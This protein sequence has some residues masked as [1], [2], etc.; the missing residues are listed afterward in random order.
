MMRLVAC[1]TLAWQ[2]NY[3]APAQPGALSQAYKRGHLHGPKDD[4]DDGHLLGEA[5]RRAADTI[6][7]LG[8]ALQVGCVDGCKLEGDSV[9]IS[10]IKQFFWKQKKQ[11][12]FYINLKIMSNTSF[13]KPP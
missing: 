2:D 13:I 6:A 9:I 1:Y 12:V 11:V 3:P 7:A 10:C 5:A 8:S 4:G